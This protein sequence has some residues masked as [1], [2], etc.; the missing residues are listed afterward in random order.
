MVYLVHSIIIVPVFVMVI[1]GFLNGT[2][3]DYIDVVSGCTWVAALAYSFWVSTH[4]GWVAVGM[5]FVYG[6]ILR[7][8]AVRIASRALDR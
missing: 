2:L 3:K 1:N 4:D 6:I 5:S 7:P 8:I